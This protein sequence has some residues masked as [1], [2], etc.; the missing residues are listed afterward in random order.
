MKSKTRILVVDDEED[1]VYTLAERLEF[2]GMVAD[3]A[4][5][6]TEAIKKFE[7]NTYDVTV[8]DM[9]MPGLNGIEL[10]NIAKHLQPGMK[11]ILITGHG[12]IEEGSR[13]KALGAVDYLVKPIKIGQLIEKIKTALN[14][15]ES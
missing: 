4:I 7:K 9:K 10:L 5:N 15:D 8:I 13:A 1:L 2:R 12:T 11:I 3:A 14:K 6:G